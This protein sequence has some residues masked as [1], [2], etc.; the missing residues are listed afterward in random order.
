MMGRYGIRPE[1]NQH[2][3][4][5]MEQM[6]T[7]TLASMEKTLHLVEVPYAL[8][9]KQVMVVDQQETSP[10]SEIAEHCIIL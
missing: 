7:D 6:I 8:T 4:N 5:I 1:G 10:D 2:H 3:N 9:G